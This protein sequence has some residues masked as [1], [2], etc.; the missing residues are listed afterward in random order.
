MTDKPPDKPWRC[1]LCG[2]K[3]EEPKEHNCPKAA[4]GN[5]ERAG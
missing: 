2:A 5:F 1:L 4:I 3:L